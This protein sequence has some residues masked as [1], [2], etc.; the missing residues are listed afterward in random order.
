MA[1]RVS[2]RKLATYAADQLATGADPIK[3]MQSVAA[4][5][6]STRRTRE[7]ELLVRDIEVALS[8]KGIVIADI[9]S[10]TP[11][12]SKLSDEIKKVVGASSLQVRAH[13]D[14]ALLGGVRIDVP[15]K[16]F[17]GTIRRKLNVLKAQQM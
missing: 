5:L 4:F 3:V 12:S 9:S 10:A 1:Q 7:Q 13:I 11:L 17:D 15:G 8:D 2:R 6:V 14:P 16:R